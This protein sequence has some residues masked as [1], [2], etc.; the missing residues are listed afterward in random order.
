MNVEMDAARLNSPFDTAFQPAGR[1]LAETL[2]P[3]YRDQ[4]LLTAEADYRVIL[5]GQM[6]A[7]WHRPRWL[8]PI[9][10][11]VAQGDMLFPEQGKA[12]PTV[13]TITAGRDE[14]GL[15]F[16]RWERRF[17][18]KRRHRS[19]NSLMV[20]DPE[21]GEV[22]EIQGPGGLLQTTSKV[23]ADPDFRTLEFL[24]IKSVLKIGPLRLALPKGLWITTHAVERLDPARDDTIHVDFTVSHPWL[25][26]IFGY[27]GQFRV[28]R[29]PL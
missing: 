11:L 15:P 22:V 3:A 19:F 14:R 1:A 4:Y 17:R 20:F 26:D 27:R 25:G 8:W 9:F 24:P 12:I 5:G 2:A 7:I 28:V 23:V 6:E 16:H 10:W 18:F 13:V 29:R 21:A